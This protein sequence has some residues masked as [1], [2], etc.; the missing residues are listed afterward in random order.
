MSI[1]SRTALTSLVIVFFIFQSLAS[2]AGTRSQQGARNAKEKVQCLCPEVETKLHFC[3]R[4]L[5]PPNCGGV[6]GTNTL[7]VCEVS[8]APA[9]E[10]KQ[11]DQCKRKSKEGSVAAC[12]TGGGTIGYETI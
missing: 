9:K 5:K 1:P 3:G 8:G 12:R 6:N 11:C 10:F 4:N 2:A 7:F